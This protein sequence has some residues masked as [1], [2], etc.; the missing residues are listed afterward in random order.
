MTEIRLLLTA[1][2]Y[3]TRI[4]VPAWV[5]HAQEQLAG[6]VRYFPVVG[7][8]VGASGAATLWLAALVLPTPLPAILA[9]IVTVLMTGA[10]HEDGLADTCDG[11]AGGATRERALE[12]MK[13]PRIGV[14]GAIALILMLLLKISALSVMP[15]WTA[16]AALIAA[17]AFSRFCAV[18]IS[19]AGRYVG[20]AERSRAAPVVQ[21]VQIG[22]VMIAALF[23]LPALVL[24]GRAAIIAIVVA[25]VLLGLLFRWCVKRIGGYTGDTLGA[26]QQ[27]TETGFYVALLATQAS[28]L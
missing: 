3:F 9:T 18:L 25:L 1:V 26:A 15:V 22:D 6:A 10:I 24:C 12:I 20:S 16:M 23:G 21:R 19:F 2:Q 28:A 7:L 4:R 8:I 14:F 5:G 27:I 13:D 17:H 11:L